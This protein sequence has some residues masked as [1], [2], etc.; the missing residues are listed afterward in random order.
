MP[1]ISINACIGCCFIC[2]L[3]LQIFT[4]RRRFENLDVQ[5]ESSL[6]LLNMAGEAILTVL[7]M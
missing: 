6:F 2:M 3:A 7:G 5:F 1:K 4:N